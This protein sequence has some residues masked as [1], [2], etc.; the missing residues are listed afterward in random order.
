ME[1][2]KKTQTSSAGET[3]DEDRLWKQ[4]MVSHAKFFPASIVPLASANAMLVMGL[5]MKDTDCHFDLQGILISG[6]AIALWLAST[7]NSARFIINLVATDG[8]FTPSEMCITK[9]CVCFINALSTSQYLWIMVTTGILSAHSIS[10][11]PK[12]EQFCKPSAVI[13]TGSL[14][15]IG[16]VVII[17]GFAFVFIYDYYKVDKITNAKS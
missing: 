1:T 16:W 13:F 14:L 4:R 9:F 15:A 10:F 3:R 11:S 7:A 2:T 17:G 6:A 5:S 12:S 8:D